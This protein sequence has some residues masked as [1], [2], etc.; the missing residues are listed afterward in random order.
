MKSGTHGIE[1]Q[2]GYSDPTWAAEPQITQRSESGMCPSAFSNNHP[3]IRQ[4][5]S[6]AVLFIL[7]RKRIYFIA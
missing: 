1:I 2:Q 6:Q 7:K 4:R 5:G 3:K